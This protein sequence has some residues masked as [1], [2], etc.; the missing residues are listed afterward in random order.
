MSGEHSA[1]SPN[2]II[3][4]PADTQ[5]LPVLQASQSITMPSKSTDRRANVFVRDPSAGSSSARNRTNPCSA[6]SMLP[7]S[8]A[9]RG[10]IFPGRMPPP[11]GGPEVGVPLPLPP[12]L[13][14]GD[15]D[16]S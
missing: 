7:L 1:C 15:E 11:F 3:L 10:S 6:T 13:V 9:A 16:E 4:T 5:L 12:R 14:V 8:W 2:R